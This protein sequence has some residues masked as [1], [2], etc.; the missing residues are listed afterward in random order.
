MTAN[1]RTVAVSCGDHDGTFFLPEKDNATV[2]T[3]TAYVLLSDGTRCSPTQF[4]KMGGKGAAKKWKESIKFILPDGRRFSIGDWLEKTVPALVEEDESKEE[5][6]E[7]VAFPI[8]RQNDLAYDT[9][10]AVKPF[11]NVA[12]FPFVQLLPDCSLRYG[13]Q[14]M[15][16]ANAYFL[17]GSVAVRSLYGNDWSKETFLTEL[18]GAI[19]KVFI[20]QGGTCGIVHLDRLDVTVA[21]FLTAVKLTFDN[22]FFPTRSYKEVRVQGSGIDLTKTWSEYVKKS[23]HTLETPL[24]VHVV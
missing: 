12:V 5:M 24:V 3:R 20:G 4:E 14:K 11:A 21:N 1:S 19:F 13:A 15:I 6:S 8:V 17:E 7:E 22:A 18:G 10:N 2:N 9:L 23:V 16:A